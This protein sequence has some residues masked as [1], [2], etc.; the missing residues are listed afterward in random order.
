[1]LLS[2]Y[3]EPELKLYYPRATVDRICRVLV[4]LVIGV[5]FIVFIDPFLYVFIVR[6]S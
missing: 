5:Y 3:S 4:V 6:F 1:M 2:C